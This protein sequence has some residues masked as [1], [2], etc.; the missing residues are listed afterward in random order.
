MTAA[1][2]CAPLP[3]VSSR[4]ACPHLTNQDGQAWGSR[5]AVIG[6]VGL[7]RSFPPRAHPKPAVVGA[8]AEFQ[9]L[10]LWL[11]GTPASPVCAESPLPATTNNAPTALPPPPPRARPTSTLLVPEV[12]SKH[13]S[14]ACSDTRT[15]TQR[16][17]HDRVRAESTGA[18]GTPPSHPEFAVQGLARHVLLFV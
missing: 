15:V 5:M 8:D 17:N 2:H 16:D 18:Q 3:V 9:R 4:C 11:A 6:M 1:A 12:P 7:L 14:A 13:L 10:V